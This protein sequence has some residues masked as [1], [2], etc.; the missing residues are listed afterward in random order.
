MP[1]STHFMQ[2][3]PSLQEQAY[4]ALRNAILSGELAPGERLVENQLSKK[5]QVSRTPIREALRQLQQDDLVIVGENNVLQVIEFSVKDAMQLYDCRLALEKLS[6]SQ[7]CEK[8]NPSQLEN[9]QQILHQFPPA[10][11]LTDFQLLDIDYHFHRLLAESSGNLWLRSLLDQVFDKM[12]VIRVYTLQKNR[13]VLNI[14]SEHQR[15]YEAIVQ[16]DAEAAIMAMTDHLIT[17]QKRVVKEMQKM[18]K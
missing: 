16:R 1:L 18:A 14:H 10:S 12:T 8:I 5:L 11:Q 9:L 3:N 13:Q 6:V 7:A 4:Q 2:R 17:A 15:I